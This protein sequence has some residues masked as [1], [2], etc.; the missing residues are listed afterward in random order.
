MYEICIILFKVLQNL[1]PINFPVVS[2]ILLFH[3]S[4]VPHQLGYLTK[5]ERPFTG[6]LVHMYPVFHP[7]KTIYLWCFQMIYVFV[8]LQNVAL[9]N[10][11]FPLYV[12][13]PSHLSKLKQ[14]HP[15]EFIHITQTEM[16]ILLF[17]PS[18]YSVHFFINMLMA[19]CHGN[20][21]TSLFLSP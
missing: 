21:C 2:S 17:W 6:P 19:I 3:K 18:L 5:L 7:C 12:E 15:G 9:S 14:E 20:R 1:I 8:L 11:P 13:I 10:I 4:H 16:I